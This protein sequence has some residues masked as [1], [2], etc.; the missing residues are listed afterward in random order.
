MTKR[1]LRWQKAT[2]KQLLLER[3]VLLLSGPRQCG[4]TTLARELESDET[5]YRTLDDGTLREAA[6]NDPQ[7]FIKRNAKTLIIDEV[8]RIPSLLPA[9]KKAVDEDTRSGQYLLTGSTDIQSLP[10]VRES[11]AGRI[12]KIRLRPLAQGE[13]E[14]AT[15]RFIDSAF[16]Q[17]FSRNLTQYDRDAVIEIAFRGGFPEPMLLQDRGRKRW[18][19]DYVNAILER[20]LKE[21]A[22]IHR[23]NAM[24]ELVHTLAAWSG[25]FMDLA[26]IGSGLSIRRPTIET[27]INTLETLYLVE[28]LYPWTK[29]DYARVG[30]QSRLFMVDSGL[31]TS[32]LSWKMDQVRLDSDRSGKLIETFTFNEIMAQ[33]DVS[34]GR[35]ELFHYRDREKREIDFLIER[36]DNAL[37]GIEIKAGS[38][39]EKKDFKHMRWFQKN[40]TKSRTFTGV[41]LYTGEF[42]A[43]FGNNLWAVPF[44]LLWS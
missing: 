20:D 42:P 16:K 23:K 40:L 3:R 17:S 7:G 2:I 27:Y 9:I 26:A 44:G 21:I 13:I 11:L 22:R 18:H 35:Y 19:T 24:R 8:Q 25:K 32:L 31:M 36:E 15:P 30:K 14:R 1:Y 5:E 10:T 39:V 43:S 41:I 12:A 34:D 28:R 4:K 38:A 6:E 29:T 33:V 37:L